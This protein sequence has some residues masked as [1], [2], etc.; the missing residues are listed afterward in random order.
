MLIFNNTCAK[1][2]FFSQLST[3]KV[4]DTVKY[5]GANVGVGGHGHANDNNDGDK[6]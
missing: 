1:N 4:H 2:Y 6:R 5:N 3:I